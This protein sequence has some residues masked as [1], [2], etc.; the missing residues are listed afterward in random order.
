MAGLSFVND[1]AGQDRQVSARGRAGSRSAL[2]IRANRVPR[3]FRRPL[4]VARA[5]VGGWRLR[6][7]CSY[8]TPALPGRGMLGLSAWAWPR[9]SRRAFLRP[10]LPRTRRSLALLVRRA[11]AAALSTSDSRTAA[12]RS[13]LR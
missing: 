4:A 13:L 10:G 12:S 7:L 11:W 3:R 9:E 2:R 1:T 6:W 5:S 8:G